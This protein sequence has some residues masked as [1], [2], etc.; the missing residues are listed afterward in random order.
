MELSTGDSVRLISETEGM[1]EVAVKVLNSKTFTV[2]NW[3]AA[4][5]GVFVYGRKV[6]DFRA[7]DYQQIFSTGISVI[8]QLSKETA[9]LKDENAKLKAQVS[10]LERTIQI[11]IKSVED[12]MAV[13]NKLPAL[14]ASK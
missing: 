6:N 14:S 4:K 11:K 1:K 13:M 10:E 7:V 12:K 2:D 3:T 8:Q 5:G 9:A